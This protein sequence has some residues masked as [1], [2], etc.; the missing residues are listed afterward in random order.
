[1]KRIISVILIVCMFNSL[2]LVDYIKADEYEDFYRE[3]YS[4]YGDYIYDVNQKSD[5]TK[6]ISIIK[7]YGDENKLDIPSVIDDVEVKEIAE[8][9][10]E[11][12][13]VT[14]ISL[15]ENITHIA[16]RAF[17][18]CK[19]LEEIKLSNKLKYI[20]M[21]AFYDCESLKSI[22]IPQSVTY[23]GKN[24]FAGSFK[25]NISKSSYLKKMKVY[26]TDN[27]YKYMALAK[28]SY[29]KNGKTVSKSYWAPRIKKIST[30]KK[31]VSIEEKETYKI[32]TRIFTKSGK[33]KGNLNRNI[34]R[35]TSSDTS[36]AKVNK[37]GKVKGIKK[38]TATIHISMRTDSSLSYDV[39][40]SV[41]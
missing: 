35:F 4:S 29:K 32:K 20:G 19:K 40:V 6:Y 27:A 16:A 13:N 10:C 37:Y 5:G 7:Y 1:M 33:R 34:L 30:S 18:G 2:L 24:A 26:G 28:V 36:I 38:G 9:F 3:N 41:E 12:E 23:C 31:K 25:G 39:K 15:G 22:T 14:Y 17:S 21:Y 8:E 11:N